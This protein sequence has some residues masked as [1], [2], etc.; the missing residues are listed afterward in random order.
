MHSNFFYKR[1]IHSSHRSSGHLTTCLT[2]IDFSTILLILSNEQEL[3]A[4]I[5]NN[6]AI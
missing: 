2:T 1:L 6:M 5:K 3:A 4:L